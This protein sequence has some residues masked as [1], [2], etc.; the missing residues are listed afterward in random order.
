MEQLKNAWQGVLAMFKKKKRHQEE[1]A[2]EEMAQKQNDAS[3]KDKSHQFFG[4]NKKIVIG[5]SAVFG[6]VFLV[7]LISSFIF[8]PD[9]KDA[10][11]K[12]AHIEPASQSAA[13]GKSNIP[14][15]Y[16][17]LA[18]YNQTAQKP[19]SATATTNKPQQIPNG[20]N[21]NVNP[22][23]QEMQSNGAYA[24]PTN[25]YSQQPMYASS[26]RM[27]QPVYTPVGVP[28]YSGVNR[29]SNDAVSTSSDAQSNPIRFSLQGLADLARSVTG[30]SPAMASANS[31]PTSPPNTGSI[32]G[33]TGNI[34]A[35]TPASPNM[36]IAGAVVPATLISGLNSDLPGQVVAQ[37]RQDVYD[38]VT[39]YTLLIPQGSRLIG[40]YSNRIGTGQNR[41]GI[42]WSTLILP[43]GG[44]YNLGGMMA[45]DLSGYAGLHDQVDNHS[46][47]VYGSALVTSFLSALGT[48]AS[49]NTTTTTGT[50]SYGQLAASGAATNLVN[51]ASKMIE[52][53]LSIQ[54]TIT[55]RPGLNFDVFV[56]R[57]LVFEPY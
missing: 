45:V 36:L 21:G 30:N 51:A 2:P 29:R 43:N 39:G 12:A 34:G 10:N 27:T 20:S 1:P 16:D 32:A 37:V 40:E 47:Q 22:A 48:I 8:S 54:P 31:N 46:G 11:K 17:G 56:S 7:A 52:K 6:G 53:N 33:G 5:T 57:S 55:I 3:V 23:N 14:V 4:I 24:A 19:G 15:T 25:S 42:S 50:Q 9:G 49:G 13:T 18:K 44:S 26:P 38:S 28:D 41:I 35:Y